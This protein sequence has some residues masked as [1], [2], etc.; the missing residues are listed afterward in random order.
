M[1]L[2]F[3]WYLVIV[4]FFIQVIAYQRVQSIFKQ[5]HISLYYSNSIYDSVVLRGRINDY[6]T[7]FLLDTGFGGHLIY[8]S[9]AAGIEHGEIKKYGKVVWENM[10]PYN[11]LRLISNGYGVGDGDSKDDYLEKKCTVVDDDYSISLVSISEIVDVDTELLMCP[12]MNLE[13]TNG[14]FVDSDGGE[15]FI[16]NKID[17]SPHI[18]TLDYLL[19]RLPVILD[20]EKGEL[21]THA[22]DI[23][24]NLRFVPSKMVDYVFAIELS[25]NGRMGYF[26][27]DTGFSGTL[28][29]YKGFEDKF[30]TSDQTTDSSV[31]QM[32]VDTE[33]VCSNIYDDNNLVIADYELRGIPVIT[34]DS[35]NKGSDGIQGYVGSMVLQ[36]FHIMISNDKKLY[37]VRNGID[38]DPLQIKNQYKIIS[39]PKTCDK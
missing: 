37:M 4:V 12:V 8:N 28:C 11:M 24:S 36:Y 29:I 30:I 19:R 22:L 7:V 3:I 33:S 14:T 31:E 15:L 20:F 27:M 18:I 35:E 34:S 5:N 6:V 39:R 21:I 38:L 1:K 23:P 13:R 26:I 9:F 2:N 25:V 16:E 32:G 10:E 17:G